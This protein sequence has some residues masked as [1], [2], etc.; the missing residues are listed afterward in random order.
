MRI[1]FDAKRLYNNFTGLGNYSRFVVSALESAF[2][3]DEYVLFTP[4]VKLNPETAPFRQHPRIRTV[5]PPPWMSQFKLG[6]VWRT[7]FAGQAAARAGVDLYHGLSHELPRNLPLSIK[8]VVTIH[9]LIFLRYPQFY[10]PIDVRIYRAKVQHACRAA[11]RIVAISRQTAQDIVTYLNIAE[12]KIEVVYQGTHPNFSATYSPAEIAGIRT[13][14]QLPPEYILNV[15][16]LEERK[17]A[18]LIVEAL[19]RLP[20]GLSIPLVLVG[21]ETA[22]GAKIRATARQLGV[23]QQ[24][25]ILPQVAFADL[26][27]I[28]QQA[29]VFIY[30][31]LFEGFGIP[32]IEA[33]QSGVPVITSQDSCFSEAAGPGAIYIDPHQPEALAAQLEKV[34]SDQAIAASMI[35]TSRE[36]IERFK[37]RAIA[38]AMH[39]VYENVLRGG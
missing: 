18:V 13:K 5:L 2:P 36:Y 31:S 37:P 11:D 35:Q 20:K 7:F 10:K 4:G 26:P 19:S 17:N 28:Y 6:S 9:D 14:Y 29:R 38:E 24:V 32:L 33:I 15:G 27:A 1:G 12:N 16:T 21:R 39:S 22:Y 34:L 8:K 23:E 25:I 30:P 3:H